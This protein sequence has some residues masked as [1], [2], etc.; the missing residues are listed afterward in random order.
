[1]NQYMDVPRID[2]TYL[3]KSAVVVI[4]V[5]A[6]LQYSVGILV[7]SPG[8]IDLTGLATIGVLYLVF[9]AVIGIVSANTAL[10][11]PRWIVEKDQ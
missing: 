3:V 9:S 8:Q 11:T 2:I 4:L 5:I 6:V 10:P 1:M 7:E